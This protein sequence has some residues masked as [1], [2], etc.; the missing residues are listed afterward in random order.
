MKAMVYRINF[1]DSKD[2]KIYENSL[3]FLFYIIYQLILRV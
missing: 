3:I 2:K 1:I